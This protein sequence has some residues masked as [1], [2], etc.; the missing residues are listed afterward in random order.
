MVKYEQERGREEEKK[1]RMIEK[2]EQSV[3]GIK[4][5]SK[6]CVPFGFARVAVSDES[7][8]CSCSPTYAHI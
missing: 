1:R 6:S 3:V 5:H 7:D 8:L 2:E 4:S